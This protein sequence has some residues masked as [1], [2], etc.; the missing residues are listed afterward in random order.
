MQKEVFFSTQTH[1]IHLAS[2]LSQFSI[3]YGTATS[4]RAYIE[5]TT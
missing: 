3:A 4:Q 5:N 1:E 2:T